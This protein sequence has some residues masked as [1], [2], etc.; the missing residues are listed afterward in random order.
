MR[1]KI[2]ITIFMI[3]I[4]VLPLFILLREQKEF[5]SL[6]NRVLTKRNDLSEK[7]IIKNDFQDNLENVLVDQMI[8]GQ[9]MKQYYNYL[10]NISSSSLLERIYDNKEENYFIPLGNEVYKLSKSNYLVYKPYS[11]DKVEKELNNHINN[12]NSIYKKYNIP[13]Y[14][15]YINK[16]IDINIYNQVNEFMKEKL[17]KNIKYDYMKMINNDNND[18]Y[19]LYKN[20]FYK[21]DHHWNYKGAFEGYKLVSKMFNNNIL[22]YEKEICFENVKFTGSK[23]KKVGDFSNYD[24]FC[25]YQFNLLEHKVYINGKETNY[26][27]KE[28]YYKNRHQNELGTNHYGLY[29]GGDYGE[30]VYDFNNDKENLLIFSNSYSNAINDLVASSFNKTYVIDLRAYEEDLGY[31]F[32]LDNYI[33]KN[34]INKILFLG[35]IN[36]YISDVFMIDM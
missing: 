3:I 35:D 24:K 9:K 7:S 34:K 10:K 18:Y 25:V 11:F 2:F 16:D 12:I 23:G 36:F 33:K 6:E 17:N 4:I 27:N 8:L 13:V 26:G 1:N 5:S 32:N 21:T 14:T 20:Y 30:V 22:D 31:K 28:L 19:N 15:F 29:Y